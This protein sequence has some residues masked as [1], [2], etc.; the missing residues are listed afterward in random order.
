ML[1]AVVDIC[2]SVAPSQLCLTTDGQSGPVDFYG[3]K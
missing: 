1:D 3:N 2:R